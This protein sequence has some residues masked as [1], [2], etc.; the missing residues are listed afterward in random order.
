MRVKI[1]GAVD[2]I[3][4][5]SS[6]RDIIM[7]KKVPESMMVVALNGEVIRREQWESLKLKADD[8]LE[9]IRIIGGG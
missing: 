1:N 6:I 9:M 3:P 2:E 5:N 7:A 4:D 8:V